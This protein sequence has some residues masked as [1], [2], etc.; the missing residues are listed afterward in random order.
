[1]DVIDGGADALDERSQRYGIEAVAIDRIEPED[2]A[3]LVDRHVVE[4]HAQP[5]TRVRPRSLG[6]WEVVPPHEVVDPD[7]VAA[8]DLG[9]VHRGRAEPAVAIDVVARLH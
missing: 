9:L 7:A 3:G 4:A 1:M 8:V 6:V 2:L 5:L